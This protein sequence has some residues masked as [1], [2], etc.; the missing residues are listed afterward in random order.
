MQEFKRISLLVIFDGWTADLDLKLNDFFR[1]ISNDPAFRQFLR[2]NWKYIEDEF[3]LFILIDTFKDRDYKKHLEVLINRLKFQLKPLGV[4]L[5]TW[6]FS[7]I[8]SIEYDPAHDIEILLKFRTLS[9][10]RKILKMY[11]NKGK[12]LNETCSEEIGME[13][14]IQDALL[15]RFYCKYFKEIKLTFDDLYLDQLKFIQ[16]YYVFEILFLIDLGYRE[17]AS[18]MSRIVLLLN[19]NNK[20]ALDTISQMEK[21]KLIH[22][23]NGCCQITDDG[24]KLLSKALRLADLIET[25]VKK[26]ALNQAKMFFENIDEK[27]GY[28]V[29]RDGSISKFSFGKILYSLANIGINPDTAIFVIDEIAKNLEGQKVVTSEEVIHS[30]IKSLLNRD[31]TGEMASKYLFYIHAKDF[32]KIHS[33]TKTYPLTRNLVY[34]RL[35]EI[36]QKQLDKFIIPDIFK[37]EIVDMVYEGIRRTVLTASQVTLWEQGETEYIIEKTEL[38]T[39]IQM[40]LRNFFQNFENLSKQGAIRTLQSYKNDIS[41]L[42]R[43]TEAKKAMKKDEFRK[44]TLTLIEKMIFYLTL[45]HRIPPCKSLTKNISVLQTSL[46]ERLQR[47]PTGENTRI[48]RQHRE[49]LRQTVKI[50]VRILR[51][52][53]KEGLLEE[54]ERYKKFLK[55]I[56]LALS[57]DL[58]KYSSLSYQQLDGTV[59]KNG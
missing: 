58:L 16:D 48:L 51:G 52:E 1:E 56:L 27:I 4:N 23:R 31:Q 10:V 57:K 32:L 43:A 5:L 54:L 19:I 3:K 22:S 44:T 29:L 2:I 50:Y 9:K 47:N 45:Q 21:M 36:L 15:Q 25:H 7:E 59:G 37:K 46:R 53:Y 35:E 17:L 6:F 20:D 40:V 41:N 55:K 26:H 14:S 28:I 12:K 30:I 11:L 8:E 38:D 49:F 39:V 42:L 13:D 24:S 34:G 18:L 33:D